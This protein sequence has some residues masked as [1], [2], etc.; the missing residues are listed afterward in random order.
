MINVV[1]M[2]GFVGTGYIPVSYTHLDVYKRQVVSSLVEKKF[3][4]PKMYH[5]IKRT[6]EVKFAHPFFRVSEEYSNVK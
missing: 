6:Y 1:Y 5:L 2:V 4:L 3:A